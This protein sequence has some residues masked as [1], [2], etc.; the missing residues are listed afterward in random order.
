MELLIMDCGS[1]RGV[2][3]LLDIQMLTGPPLLKIDAPP[4]ATVFS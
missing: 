1:K 2:L 4:P 3:I